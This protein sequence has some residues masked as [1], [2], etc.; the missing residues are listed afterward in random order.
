MTHPTC[1]GAIEAALDYHAETVK[2]LTV[3]G[4]RSESRSKD[5][6]LIPLHPKYKLRVRPETYVAARFPK[7]GAELSM[8]H[9][10]SF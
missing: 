7:P 8:A 1:E 5:N 3:N 10:F 4:I 2:P 9:V 6:F